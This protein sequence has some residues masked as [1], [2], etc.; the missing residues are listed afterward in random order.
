MRRAAPPWT[1]VHGP[2]RAT[3]LLR[4]GRLTGKPRGQRQAG[5]GA[6]ERSD[7]RVGKQDLGQGGGNLTAPWGRG[8]DDVAKNKGEQSRA[9]RA[10]GIAAISSCSGS[11]REVVNPNQTKGCGARRKKETNISLFPGI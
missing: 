10:T 2:G 6:G 5:G 4:D 3:R 9:A 11:S 7:R 1:S 8:L